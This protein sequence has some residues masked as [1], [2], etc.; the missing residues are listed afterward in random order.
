MAVVKNEQVQ[1]IFLI[2]ILNL[3]SDSKMACKHY[4]FDSFQ[5]NTS[6]GWTITQT[7]LVQSF[8]HLFTWKHTNLSN[9]GPMSEVHSFPISLFDA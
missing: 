5:P 1:K 9:K 3:H 6:K 4:I 8:A 7:F 2:H